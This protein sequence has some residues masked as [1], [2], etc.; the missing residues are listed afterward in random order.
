MES[1]GKDV[2]FMISSNKMETFKP[3]SENA[4][5]NDTNDDE[6]KPA[7]VIEEKQWMKNR[8]IRRMR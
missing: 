5:G 4:N 2:E 8:Q 1:E 7:F 3:D 6:D